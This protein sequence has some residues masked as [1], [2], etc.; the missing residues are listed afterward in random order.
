MSGSSGDEARESVTES[1]SSSSNSDNNEI[2]KRLMSDT[3]EIN[4]EWST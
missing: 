1:D 3:E 2:V 4:H